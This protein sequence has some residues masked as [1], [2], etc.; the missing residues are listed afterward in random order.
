MKQI[1]ALDLN[2]NQ[3]R[4]I[5]QIFN[6]KLI[7]RVQISKD[8]NINKATISSILNKLKEKKLV[9]EVGHGESTKSGGRKPI[10]L[11]IN[12]HFGYVISLDIAYGSIEMIYN[13][14]NGEILKHESI[15][16]SN[17]KMSHV[18]DLLKQHINTD[19]KYGTHHGLLGISISVH[20]IV[21]N[22]QEIVHLPFHEIEDISITESIKDIAN[23][24]IIVENEANLSAIYECNENNDLAVNNLI[25]LSIHKGIGA[26][27]II[28]KKLYRGTDGEAGE[29]GKTLVSVIQNNH[30][31]FHKI[32]DICSQD[33]LVHNL[34]ERLNQKLTMTALKKLYYDKN[35]IVV[36]EINQFSMRIAILIYNLNMQINPEAIYINC[37]LINE[38]PDVLEAIKSAFMTYTNKNVEICLTSN[39]KFSTLLG[40]TLAITQKVLKIDNIKLNF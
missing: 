25:T 12:K 7:S 23:V 22:N 33:A 29:I 15:P 30:K 32:E 36:D 34:E 16:L 14:F 9:N 37:P 35:E 19:E 13:Y 27:L 26:G 10:L 5:Q 21:N 31:T 18:L 3:R 2:E 24:P 40:A 20:G 4:V 11:E 39:V 1:D 28:D 8:L 17:K 38:L 6:N